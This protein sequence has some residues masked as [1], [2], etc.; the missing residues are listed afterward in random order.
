MKR[1]YYHKYPEQQIKLRVNSCIYK[2]AHGRDID[3]NIIPRDETI[4]KCRR[5]CNR[6]EAGRGF[7]KC[8]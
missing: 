8:L 1:P 5:C 6:C 3:G 2:D 4:L 7:E